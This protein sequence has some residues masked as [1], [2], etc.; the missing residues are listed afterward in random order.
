M[1]STRYAYK[2]LYPQVIERLG[3]LLRAGSLTM[4]NQVVDGMEQTPAALHDVLTGNHIGKMLVRYSEERRGP[5]LSAV[6]QGFPRAGMQAS[7]R[8][9][10]SGVGKNPIY[11]GNYSRLD[12]DFGL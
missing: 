9:S 12:R 2:D 3:A 1:R 5:P 8:D 11:S 6:R 10:F 4:H 7:V